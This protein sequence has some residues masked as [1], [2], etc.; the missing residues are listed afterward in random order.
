MNLSFKEYSELSVV[1]TEEG[2]L[3]EG[4]LT[5]WLKKLHDKLVKSGKSEDE[6]EKELEKEKAKFQ[7]GAAKIAQSQA[8]K[9]FYARKAAREKE[10]AAKAA[11]QPQG[12]RGTVSTD[13]AAHA[14]ARLNS[15][16]SG[17]MRAAQARAAEREF[18]MG[19][20]K[21]TEGKMEFECKYRPK[22]GGATRKWTCSGRD[23][24][25]VRRKFADTHYGAKLISISPVKAKKLRDEDDE[26]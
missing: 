11:R 22:G 18:A 6:I 25:D 19:E 23:A 3:D 15:T 10:A 9:D 16:P 21:L 13:G 2:Q 8:S 1:L 17:Q 7:A 20:E 14:K 24:T 5:D 4:K 26:S 12:T